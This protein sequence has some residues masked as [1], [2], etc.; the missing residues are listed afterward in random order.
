MIRSGERAFPVVDDH[1]DFLGL[2]T[3]A[4]MRK[5]PREA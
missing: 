4:D 3:F 1:G 5:V 2:V